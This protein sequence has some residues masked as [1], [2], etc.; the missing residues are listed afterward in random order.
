[1]F[2]HGPPSEYIVVGAFSPSGNGSPDTNFGGTVISSEGDSEIAAPVAGYSIIDTASFGPQGPGDPG[3]V[4]GYAGAV[5]V[6][7][8]VDQNGNIDIA[9]DFPGVSGGDSPLTG[10]QGVGVFQL[11]AN[12]T[13]LNYISDDV[14][15]S[16]DGG[17]DAGLDTYTG[18]SAA[19]NP[20]TNDILIGGSDYSSSASVNDDAIW[21]FNATSGLVDSSFGPGGGGEFTIPGTLPQQSELG[22]ENSDEFDAITVDSN[23]SDSTYGDIYAADE[24]VRG[25]A[26]VTAITSDGSGLLASFNG[27]SSY[28]LS[29]FAPAGSNTVS[30]AS[31]FGLGIYGGN[32]IMADPVS[33]V[34]TMANSYSGVGL[35]EIN[36]ATA[37]PTNFGPNTDGQLFVPSPQG[38]GVATWDGSFRSAGQMA[39][40]PN[41]GDIAITYAAGNGTEADPWEGFE[42]EGPMVLQWI[43][44]IEWQYETL[45]QTYTNADNPNYVPTA[46]FITTGSDSGGLMAA[47]IDDAASDIALGYYGPTSGP[48]APQLISAASVQANA[49]GNNYAIPINLNAGQGQLPTVEGREDNSRLYLALD[50]ASPIALPSDLSFSLVDT[51]GIADGSVASYSI[52]ASDPNELDIYLS[53]VINQQTLIF[54][55]VGVEDEATGVADTVGF[56]LGFLLGDCAGGSNS[57]LPNGGA[58][59]VVNAEDFTPLSNNFGQATNSTNYLA[60]FNGDSAVNAEDFTDFAEDLGKALVYQGN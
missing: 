37:A 50:F 53:D 27:G 30:F 39:I 40:N 9:V 31:I 24:Y 12:G 14:S 52:N 59:G 34:D 58:D 25:D 6:G 32:L 56:R 49:N 21:A 44:G 46:T 26:R 55:V 57:A 42:P 23:P 41:N 45:D 11:S 7:I 22:G 1:M 33:W 36:A 13:G 15:P 43:S 54:S 28:Q 18:F 17:S 20:S 38:E 51:Q 16:A 8:F 35:T 19:Y 60:D 5:P 4:N 3:T 2:L 10:T 48:Y 29:G 47:D